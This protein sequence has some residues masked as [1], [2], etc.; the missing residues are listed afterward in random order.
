MLLDGGIDRSSPEASAHPASTPSAR[1]SPGCCR[2]AAPAVAALTSV[3]QLVYREI[4]E[5]RTDA[6]WVPGVVV[7]A[8]PPTP[9][10]R[11]P[12]SARG[13]GWATHPPWPWRSS[14]TRTTRTRR[15][16]TT[17]RGGGPAVDPYLAMSAAG[18]R[19]ARGGERPPEE[20]W[21]PPGS[22][23][24]AITAATTRSRPD[25]FAAYRRASAARSSPAPSSPGPSSATPPEIVRVPAMP[26]GS[27]PR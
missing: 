19:I 22:T 9:S 21:P 3:D 20:R 4:T 17:R 8:T 13:S 18:S 10:A 2:P 11:R 27:S 16:P 14:G 7:S 23:P 15:A 6:W 24:V 25:D 12:A 5:V 26:D 1:R